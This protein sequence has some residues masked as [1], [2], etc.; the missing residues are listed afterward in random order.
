MLWRHRSTVEP[1]RVVMLKTLRTLRLPGVS[2]EE[3]QVALLARDLSYLEELDLEHSKFS[4][5]QLLPLSQMPSLRRLNISNTRVTCL[6]VLPPNL[7]S[8]GACGLKLEP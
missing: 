5:S 6:A 3:C 1:A 4:N 7:S 8:L 2:F